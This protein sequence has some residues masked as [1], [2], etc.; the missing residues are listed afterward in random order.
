M[1]TLDNLT[2]ALARPAARGARRGWRDGG[3]D[4]VSRSL[5]GEDDKANGWGEENMSVSSRGGGRG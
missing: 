5:R 2:R 3:C 4:E 1:A